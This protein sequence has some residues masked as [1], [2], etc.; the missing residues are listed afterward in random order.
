ML[1]LLISF[2]KTRN[3]TCFTQN[4]FTL[5]LC[6]TVSSI[7]L[8]NHN[9]YVT[10]FFVINRG[11]GQAGFVTNEQDQDGNDTKAAPA[12]RPI[13]IAKQVTSVACGKDHA[14]LLTSLGVV[15]SLGSGR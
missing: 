8:D 7:K 4:L 2:G 12:F 11:T 3:L 10:L 1:R 15:Q 6:N 9:N 14:L 13:C 5:L